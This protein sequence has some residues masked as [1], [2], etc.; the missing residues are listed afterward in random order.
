MP[1]NCAGERAVLRC[2]GSSSG[3]ADT[4][5]RMCQACKVARPASKLLAPQAFVCPGVST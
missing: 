5:P 2:R 1:E 4:T 3:C